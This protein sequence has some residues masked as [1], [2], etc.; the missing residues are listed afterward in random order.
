M[1]LRSYLEGTQFVH[2]RDHQAPRWLLNLKEIT[3]R[4]AQ[5]WPQLSKFD[6]DMIHWSG[7]YHQAPDAMTKLPKNKD[8]EEPDLIDEDITTLDVQS[9][10]NSNGAQDILLFEDSASM[11]I[12][13]GMAGDQS[14]DPNCRNVWSR[15]RLDLTHLF[16]ENGWLCTKST[17]DGNIQKIVL[18]NYQATV[19][20][21]VHYQKL[22]S[23]Q[24]ARRMH[25][26][27]RR[28]YYWPHLSTYVYNLKSQGLSCRRYRPI[29]KHRQLLKFS[30]R[31]DFS[32]LRE[33]TCSGR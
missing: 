8:N 1:A 22:A 4:L 9:I 30:Y 10:D 28:Q 19:L 11:P 14:E 33:W 26:S 21:H 7:F 32:R 2:C 20:H 18:Q 3:T 6:F 5:W 23:H 15:A 25:G 12:E 31:R 16:N 27:L 17:V 24:D 29:E 13:A